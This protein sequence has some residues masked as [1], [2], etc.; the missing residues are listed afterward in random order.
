MI[1]KLL[2]VAA[3]VAIPASALAAVTTIGSS[4]AAFA[5]KTYTSQTCTISGNVVFAA[6]GLSYNGSVGKKS[7]TDSVA[8][9]TFTGTGCGAKTATSETLS[10]KIASTGTDCKTASPPPA[11]CSAATTKEYWL[12]DTSSSLASAGVSSI[13]ASLGPKGLKLDDNG[14]TVKGA[15]TSGG[16]SQV[17]PGGACGTNV[18]F[19]VQG[20]TNVAGLTYDLLLCITGDTGTNTTGSF[21]ND[22]IAS[23]EGDPSITIATGIF[24]GSSLLTFTKS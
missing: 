4:G 2:V 9:S 17:A 24:G 14:N 15:V 1:R 3:A 10:L 23:S 13:V 11:G 19:D 18:G 21:Y 16:T 12:Y 20:N 6:P 8:T 22:Y 7:V 5:G